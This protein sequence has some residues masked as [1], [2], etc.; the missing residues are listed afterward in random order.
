MKMQLIISSCI[1]LSSEAL[2]GFQCNP[3]TKNTNWCRL[4]LFICIQLVI[5]KIIEYKRYSCEF[6]FLIVKLVTISL[7][8][9]LKREET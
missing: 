4:L 8:N 2:L 1:S 9:A 6:Y 7:V 3:F 5:F